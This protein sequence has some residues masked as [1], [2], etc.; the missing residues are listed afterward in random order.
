MS[1]CGVSKD[2]RDLLSGHTDSS[3]GAA[4]VH[5]HSLVAMRSAMEKL[6]FDGVDVGALAK[7]AVA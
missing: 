2:M 7:V 3:A 1:V 4:Y 6:R 5:D